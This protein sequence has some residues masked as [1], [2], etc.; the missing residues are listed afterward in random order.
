MKRVY[1]NENDLTTL[2]KYEIGF[3]DST[4]GHVI[5]EEI[6]ASDVDV[7][8]FN[9]QDSLCPEI[10]ED[11]LLKSDVRM[12]LLNIADDFIDYLS[13]DWVKPDDIILTGSICNYNWSEFSDIDLHI[14]VDFSKVDENLKLLKEY[15]S[16]KKTNWN[17]DHDT[18]FIYGYPVELYVQDT[19]E[20]HV[21]SGIYSLEKN[22]W[23]VEPDP[24]KVSTENIDFD[25]IRDSVAQLT[26][27]VD[28]LC[29]MLE[30]ETDLYCI[31]LVQNMAKIILKGIKDCRKKGFE[32]TGSEINEGNIVFKA[33]RRNDSIQ[34]LY[35]L[36]HE[37]YDK[38][39]SLT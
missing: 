36:L 20:E 10:W 13:I 32:K 19:N 35:D 23:L 3:D 6:N 2:D 18:L 5:D 34:K 27:K 25:A 11:D 29:D 8:S 16:S 9:V 22:E 33:L 12:K 24:A 1:I 7:S 17:I 30:E 38:I 31:S 26:N 37:T 14:L 39:N 21:S 15:F 4:Y 28:E